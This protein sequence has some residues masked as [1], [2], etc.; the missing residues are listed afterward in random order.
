MKTSLA[1]RR[2]MALREFM[3][4]HKVNASALQ[5]AN[6]TACALEGLHEHTDNAYGLL[7]PNHCCWELLYI[8]A[9]KRV[10]SKF[11]PAFDRFLADTT[12]RNAL[13]QDNVKCTMRE[14]GNCPA[15]FN[16]HVGQICRVCQM[17]G[18]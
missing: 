6:C 2:V 5:K 4:D 14:F 13:Y 17:H 12:P 7:S 16:H 11:I 1:Q 15:R 9:G 18:G 10:P 3:H 8:E